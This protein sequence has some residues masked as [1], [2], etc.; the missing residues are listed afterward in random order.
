MD[1][2]VMNAS[3]N[4][5]RRLPAKDVPKNLAAISEL[6]QDDEIRDDVTVKTDKPLGRY[7][8][9]FD[10]HTLI[11]QSVTNSISYIQKLVTM[12]KQ[13]KSS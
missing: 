3:M 7:S 12:S 10:H 4:L 1:N 13:V 9:A 5:L 11:Q 8:I 6:I 2:T